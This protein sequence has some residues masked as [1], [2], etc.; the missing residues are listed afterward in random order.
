MKR[1][2]SDALGMEK[3]AGLPARELMTYDEVREI[4]PRRGQPLPRRTLYKWINRG[5]LKKVA[6]GSL[7][8]IKRD[9]VERMMKNGEA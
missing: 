3:R 1:D 8:W 9:S 7:R 5:L 4:F 2:S 6:V